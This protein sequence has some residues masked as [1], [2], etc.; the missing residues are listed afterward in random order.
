MLS[1]VT[2][3]SMLLI[4]G[5]LV[6]TTFAMSGDRAPGQQS[7][8]VRFERPTWVAGEMLIGTYVIVHDEDKMTRGEPCTA[9][10]LV[11]P[12]NTSARRS[13]VLPLHTSRAEG[14]FQLLD[15]RQ[16]GPGARHR[17]VD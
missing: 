5:T 6:P 12:A 15:H 16:L 2:V 13:R 1:R 4:V 14:H 11:G 7:A 3:A 17:Y 9:L 8:M 10:Y